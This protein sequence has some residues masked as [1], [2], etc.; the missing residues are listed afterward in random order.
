MFPFFCW[1]GAWWL[2]PLIGMVAFMMLVCVLF[3]RVFRGSA[4]CCRPRRIE[5]MSE[6]DRKAR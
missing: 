1:P 4:F 5:D 6:P 3:R 2:L